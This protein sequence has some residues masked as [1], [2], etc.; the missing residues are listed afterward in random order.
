MIEYYVLY[1]TETELFLCDGNN[2]WYPEINKA[3]WYNLDVVKEFMNTLYDT[4]K[5]FNIQDDVKK[6]ALSL[7]IKDMDFCYFVLIENN[8]ANFTKMIKLKQ[9][10]W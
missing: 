9:Y 5:T 3:S 1:N 8:E 10:E 6:I 4:T 2:L 7:E